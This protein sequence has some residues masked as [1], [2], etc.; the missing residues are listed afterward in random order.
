MFVPEPVISLSIKPKQTKDTPNFSKAMA[1]FQR[2]DPTFAYHDSASDQTIISGMGELHLDIYVERMRREYRVDCETGQPQVAYRET[3]GQARRVRSPLKKQSGG[4]GE[5]ARVMGWMEPY[6]SSR[7]EQI[8]T[9]SH[10]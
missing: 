9:A 7:G 6:W 8:R 3:L 4:S 10:R 2:E 5:Y 1:R